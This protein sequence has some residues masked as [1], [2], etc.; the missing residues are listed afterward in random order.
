[1]AKKKQSESVPTGSGRVLRQQ[2][3]STGDGKVDGKDKGKM[4]VEVKEKAKGNK[5]GAKGSLKIYDAGN[6]ENAGKR[7]VMIHEGNAEV[8]GS[9]LKR[10]KNTN[11]NEKEKGD[12]SGRTQVFTSQTSKKGDEDPNEKAAGKQ[13]KSVAVKKIVK[14]DTAAKAKTDKDIVEA[15]VSSASKSSKSLLLRQATAEKKGKRSLKVEATGQGQKDLEP[16]REV[17][18]RSAKKGHLELQK[19]LKGKKV[20]KEGAVEETDS[21]ADI[22]ISKICIGSP[23]PKKVPVPSERITRKGVQS[24]GVQSEEN[25]EEQTTG[26]VS[27]SKT[28]SKQVS[29]SQAKKDGGQGSVAVRK[30]PM[31]KA[32]ADA[33]TKK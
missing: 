13:K 14:K 20:V 27:S 6:S 4:P 24:E 16:T 10:I 11:K 21:D 26:D 18:T 12:V 1:M 33:E 32:R 29:K 19:D 5:S 9:S 22:P 8:A 3:S 28:V 17:I 7:K 31:R 30:N 25:A 15:N 2:K 23:K